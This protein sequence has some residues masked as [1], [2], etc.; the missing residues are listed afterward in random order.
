MISKCSS[1]ASAY[2]VVTNVLKIFFGTRK[3]KV[4]VFT[5]FIKYMALRKYLI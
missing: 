4:L 3:I 5:L 2:S 1:T